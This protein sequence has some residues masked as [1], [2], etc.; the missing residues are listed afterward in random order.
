MVRSGSSTF[1]APLKW[2]KPARVFTCSWSDFFLE[3]ADP[4][5]DEAW[6]IIRRTPHLTY[7]ILTKRPESIKD[8]L[9]SGWPLPNVWMGVTAE[10]QEMADK[11]I[12]ILLKIPAAVR[13]V[14]VEPMLGQVVLCE[15]CKKQFPMMDGRQSN[16]F[17]YHVS[18]GN[19]GDRCM[20]NDIDW[21]ICGGES[22]PNPR[23]M[24]KIWAASLLNYCL[25]AGVPFFMKQMS[26]RQPIPEYLNVREFPSEA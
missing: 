16:R 11:R 20:M 1:S 17:K 13:F 4:W 23:P 3:D 12:P 15:Y 22:G 18:V 9:P 21:V 8:R 7:L 19:Y 14:S 10:N 24:E 6:E 5:R 26:G 2:K 25:E